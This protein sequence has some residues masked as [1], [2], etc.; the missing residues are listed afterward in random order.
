MHIFMQIITPHLN[1]YGA[2]HTQA[3]AWLR[4]VNP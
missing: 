4:F 1:N 2:I 3:V